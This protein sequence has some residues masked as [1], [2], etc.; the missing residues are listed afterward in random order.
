MC[1][2]E[3]SLDIF[4][5]CFRR[6]G[7]PASSPGSA[8]LIL[9]C[10][11]NVHHSASNHLVSEPDVC[12]R[13]RVRVCVPECVRPRVRARAR[14]LGR[15]CWKDNAAG[16]GLVSCVP[17]HGQYLVL[18]VTHHSGVRSRGMAKARVPFHSLRTEHKNISSRHF[19]QRPG[20][21]EAIHF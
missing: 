17:K 5:S 12:M 9:K 4:L 3:S 10:V 1:A 13:T 6:R 15:L 20:G 7:A 14:V 19:S 16:T 18:R 21:G 2:R 8:G 11:L